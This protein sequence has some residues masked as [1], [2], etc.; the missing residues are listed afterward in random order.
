M[1]RFA[2]AGGAL[3]S[4]AL[5]FS[6]GSE[7]QTLPTY[8]PLELHNNV[9]VPPHY[10]APPVNVP[11]VRDVKCTILFA[12]GLGGRGHKTRS[13]FGP[14]ASTADLYGV[15]YQSVVPINPDDPE[16]SEWS[17]SFIA[18]LEKEESEGRQVIL[19]GY[20]MGAREVLELV[21]AL[22]DPSKSTYN[23]QLLSIISGIA[24]VGGRAN[25]IKNSKIHPELKNFEGHYETRT[26][27]GKPSV[28]ILPQVMETIKEEFGDKTV[29]F[30][31]LGD[32]TTTETEGKL[33]ASQIG[34]SYVSVVAMDSNGQADNHFSLTESWVP[35]ARQ[36]ETFILKNNCPL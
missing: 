23:R 8:Q 15:N 5:I 11:E 20:S 3:L 24:I 35:I 12:D 1:S 6:S 18:Q 7:T 25:D 31:Q 21:D 27:N 30:G 2:T 36:I 33:L 34:A 32:T 17:A 22:I 19:L 28:N 26:H 14:I 4:G 10:E 13:F 29:V 16:K 9:V